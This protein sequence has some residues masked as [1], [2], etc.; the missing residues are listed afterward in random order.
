MTTHLDTTIAAFEKGLTEFAAAQGVK[1]IDRWLETLEKA[2]FRGAKIIHE[3]LG[4]LKKH[5]EADEL[6]GPAIGELLRTLGEETGR[7][8]SHVEGA[9]AEKIQRLADLLGQ[10]GSD[11]S[12]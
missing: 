4:K 6:D 1:N 7:T 2:D 3:N 10:S 9:Q 5:L 12:K 8:A 11:L